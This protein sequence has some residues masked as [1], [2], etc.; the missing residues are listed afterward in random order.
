MNTDS[1]VVQAWGGAGAW[2]RGKRG[3]NWRTSVI[4]ST[5]KLN[6][7]SGFYQALD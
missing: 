2:R 1:S 6:K 3:K 5:I 4:M 7:K